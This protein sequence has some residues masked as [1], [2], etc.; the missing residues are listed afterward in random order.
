VKLFGVVLGVM[1]AIP[2]VVGA[3][4][5][6]PLPPHLRFS[7]VLAG[8]SVVPYRK[9][10]AWDMTVMLRYENVI[11]LRGRVD[12]MPPYPLDSL[13]MLRDSGYLEYAEYDRTTGGSGTSDAM[14]PSWGLDSL[15]V[16]RA[17]SNG[18]TGQGVRVGVLD[19][20]FETQHPEFAGRVERCVSFVPIDTTTPMVCRQTVADCN[21]HGTHVASTALG[22]TRGVAPGATLLAIKI[23]EELNGDCIAWSSTRAAGLTYARTHGAQVVNIS[24]GGN[25]GGAGERNTVQAAFDAGIVVC[26]SS[27]N[28]GGY[29]AYFPGAFPAALAIGAVTST[30]ARASYSNRDTLDLDF[31]FPGSSI[32]GAIGASS[33][34]TKSGTS[35]ASP[36]CAGYFALLKEALPSVRVD[37]L[38]SLARAAS[39]DLGT[40]GHDPSYGWGLPRADMGSALALGLSTQP[41]STAG[42]LVF[43]GTGTQCAPVESFVEWTLSIA[44]GL[45]ISR[46]PDRVCVTVTDPTP[47]SVPLTLSVV[48]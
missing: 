43:S 6:A 7:V 2:P 36:H 9:F 20:G 27:G 13:R 25:T 30:L 22:A 28:D 10:A 39:K 24:T 47:R 38:W 31:A 15:R 17:W 29:Q 19:T 44:P 4:E 40:A 48:R 37:S 21:H 46:E 3:Q 33:Y 11:A 1:A 45:T 18:L 23:F 41:T 5:A 12:S 14:L 32:N 8:D 16:Q 34:G 26:G 35:M 42:T